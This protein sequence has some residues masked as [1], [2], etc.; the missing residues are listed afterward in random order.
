MRM[1]SKAI[2]TAQ[3]KVTIKGKAYVCKRGVSSAFSAN[4]V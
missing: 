1:T 2:V 3:R 4:S